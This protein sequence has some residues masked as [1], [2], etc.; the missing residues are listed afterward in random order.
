MSVTSFAIGFVTGWVVRS[1]VES[2]RELAVDVAVGSQDVLHKLRRAFVAEREFL[3]DLWSEAKARAGVERPP[4]RP[5]GANDTDGPLSRDGAPRAEAE[6][7][8]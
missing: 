8:S 4:P 6:A 3:E 5:A 7:P 2:S 1:T